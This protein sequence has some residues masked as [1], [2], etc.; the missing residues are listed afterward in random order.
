MTETERATTAKDRRPDPAPPRIRLLR[1]EPPPRVIVRDGASEMGFTNERIMRPISA[2]TPTGSGA[3]IA[4]LVLSM[5]GAA[6]CGT[7]R[8]SAGARLDAD[9]DGLSDGETE[10]D[11]GLPAVTATLAPLFVTAS[12]AACEFSAPLAI[13]SGGQSQVLI[14][15]ADG[16]F[17]A[18]DA[19]TGLEAWHVALPPPAG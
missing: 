12:R 6:S 8:S 4:A 5:V 15:T 14:V 1:P 11:G 18:L 19:T 9:A 3:A 17:T 2:H 16:T 13:T 7:G 10:G